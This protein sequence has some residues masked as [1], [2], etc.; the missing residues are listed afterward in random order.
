MKELASP[1]SDASPDV[2]WSRIETFTGQVTHDVRNGLNA[3]DL[4]LTLLSQLSTDADTLSE[5]KA[6]RG[7]VQDIA[8]LLQTIRTHCGPVNPRLLDYP[9][10][11]FFE[12]LH[13]RF[14]RLHPQDAGRCAWSVAAEGVT[15]SIDPELMLI[16][17]LELFANALHFGRIPLAMSLDA[18]AGADGRLSV[19]LREHPNAAPALPCAEWGRTPLF[20]TRRGAYGL[21]LFRVRRIIEMHGGSYSVAYAAETGLLTSTVALPCAASA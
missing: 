14:Q 21:G 3:L 20:T 12:D 17:F 15:L 8:R 13:D 6:M 19:T 10:P 2:P 7:T 18:A 5:I 9:A 4:Q 11:D 1:P 16:A